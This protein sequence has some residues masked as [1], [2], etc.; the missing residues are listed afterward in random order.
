MLVDLPAG[1]YTA[2]VSGVG[3]EIG[4]AL[5][6]LYDVDLLTQQRP[7][8]RLANI[9]TRGITGNDENVVIAGFVISGNTPKKVLVRA[10]GTELTKYGVSDVLADPLINLVRQDGPEPGAVIASNDDWTTNFSAVSEAQT[11]IGAFPLDSGSGSSAIV[12]WLAPGVYTA[13]ASS[14]NEASGVALVEMYELP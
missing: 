14:S 7:T 4:A 12:I 1:S 11:I 10:V 6:E 3:G 2:L 9:S 8:T 13:L 5:V